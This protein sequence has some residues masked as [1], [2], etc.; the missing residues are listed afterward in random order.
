MK[1]FAMRLDTNSVLDL[2]QVLATLDFFM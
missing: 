1:L 2:K